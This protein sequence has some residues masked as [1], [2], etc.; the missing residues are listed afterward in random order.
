MK[1]K[2]FNLILQGLLL[3]FALME[4]CTANKQTFVVSFQPNIIG[5]HFATND[6]WIE[7]NQSIPKVNEFT[8]CHWIRI[9]FFNFKYAA[10]LW[11]YCTIANEGD[12]MKCLR[13]CLN[14][15]FKTA[16]RQTI[17]LSQ[18]PSSKEPRY[19]SERK[20]YVIFS[21]R[22]RYP[23]AKKIC[24]IHGG[25][26]ALPKSDEENRRMI[27][28]SPK[29]T[30]TC[31]EPASSGNSNA[32][33]IG[34][35][36]IMHQWYNF[37]SNKAERKPLNYSNVIQIGSTPSSE[38]AYLGKDGGWLDSI[39]VCKKVSLCTICLVPENVML[40]LKGAWT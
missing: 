4:I 10:C 30:Y 22:V 37:D 11:S 6:S 12:K 24:E 25:R 35:K 38:C 28:I 32:V 29:H 5:S 8:V 26:L 3:I 27:E 15:V 17:L 14:G 18:I 21:E 9:K 7:F 16:N 33:W 2:N 13:L 20:H 36:K 1:M 19:L 31:T 39:Y 34:A 40:T 23:N